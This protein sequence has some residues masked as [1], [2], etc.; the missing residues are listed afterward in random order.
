MQR[1]Q[2]LVLKEGGDSIYLYNIAENLFSLPFA[3]GAVIGRPPA[4]C[5]LCDITGR[6]NIYGRVSKNNL[7]IIEIEVNGKEGAGETYECAGGQ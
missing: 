2:L 6:E 3:V 4:L 1:K 7:S 5:E